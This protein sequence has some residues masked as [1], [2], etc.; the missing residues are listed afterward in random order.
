MWT[1]DRT[2]RFLVGLNFEQVEIRTSARCLAELTENVER[3]GDR[4]AD[5]S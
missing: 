2:F 3:E 4:I 5:F 1:V